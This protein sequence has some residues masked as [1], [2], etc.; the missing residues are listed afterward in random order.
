LN[1]YHPCEN[2]F[3]AVSG[4]ADS[5]ALLTALNTLKKNGIIKNEIFCKHVEHGLRPQ[6]ESC[7]DADFVRNFC[8]TNNIEYRI[9]HIPP[10][11]IA[12]LAQRKGIGIEA[13][14]RFFRY[15]ALCKEAK[16]LDELLSDSKG[17]SL[18]VKTFILVAHTKDDTLELSLMR[19]LRGA[20]TAGLAAMPERRG[21]ILRPLL[22]MTRT[23]II[24]YLKAKNVTWRDD[25]TN[26][27]VKYLRNRIRCQLIPLLNESFPS[28]KK[29][30]VSMMETQSLVT[31]FL[32]SETQIRIKWNENDKPQ[33]II[34]TDENNFFSQPQIIR[35]EALFQ[36]INIL[37]SLRG[38]RT[39][40]LG[41]ANLGFANLGFD[42]SS[43]ESS[44]IKS[45][46][47]AVIRKFCDGSVKTADLGPVKV[48]CENN[49]VLLL[50]TRKEFFESG[51]SRL[52]N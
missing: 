46:K 15:K 31:D 47:R 23:D 36:G 21:R 3:V 11:K 4:G 9:K 13:A 33:T 22:S 51:F 38:Q 8:Q 42:T 14:A 43:R 16:N 26:I 49:K 44:R 41:F 2:L 40:N 39:A 6:E 50:I 25:S 28:W 52:I 32:T 5:M 12:N 45:I 35:E 20:G 30:V 10:G 17:E 48:K 1:K 34:S 19:I 18:K 37:S 7:G 29:G 27:D 24:S